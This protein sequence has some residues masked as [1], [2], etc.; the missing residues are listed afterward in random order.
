VNGDLDCHRVKIDHL[1]SLAHLVVDPRDKE[2]AR[3]RLGN[4]DMLALLAATGDGRNPCVAVEEVRECIPVVVRVAQSSL[5]EH[6][7]LI[8]AESSRSGPRSAAY[9]AICSAGAA[10]KQDRCNERRCEDMEHSGKCALWRRSGDLVR[11][12]S[13]LAVYT[14]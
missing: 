7:D 5:V 11:V 4:L 12:L 8:A 6:R 2:Q 13:P 3:P 10:N 9:Q 14:A 1:A